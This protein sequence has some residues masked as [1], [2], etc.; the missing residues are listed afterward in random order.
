[1][2][3]SFACRSAFASLRKGTTSSASPSVQELASITTGSSPSPLQP[4]SAS[5]V[6]FAIS[7]APS[8]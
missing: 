4:Q 2:I 1:M 7:S 8:R 5:T 3:S 6:R